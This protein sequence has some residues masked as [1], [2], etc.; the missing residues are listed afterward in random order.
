MRHQR[1]VL[2]AIASKI[3][4][5]MD[6]TKLP[7]LI[8]SVSQMVITDMSVQ[9]I[10]AVV[11]AMR[12]MDVDSIYSGNVPS[13][14]AMEGGVSYVIADDD[15]LE[16]MMERVDAGEDPKAPQTMG[17]EGTGGTVGDLSN[18]TSDEWSSGT[19]TTQ[20]STSSEEEGTSK[21]TSSTTE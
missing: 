4:N 8:D 1:Q 16:E 13:T 3:L 9:D 14:T 19:A 11:N 10:L 20:S 2:G 17:T 21:G 7:A 15:A 12:G 5:D 6:A 18:N